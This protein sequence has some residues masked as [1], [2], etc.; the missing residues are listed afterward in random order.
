LL[1]LLRKNN[2]LSLY[3]VKYILVEGNKTLDRVVVRTERDAPNRRNLL[4]GNWQIEESAK[5]GRFGMVAK[6]DGAGSDQ[7]ITLKTPFMFM[8]S[9]AWQEFDPFV[10]W[11][12]VTEPPLLLSFDARGPEGGAAGFLRVEICSDKATGKTIEAEQIGL[13]WRHFELV[14][15]FPP[16]ISHPGTLTFRLLTL[17]ERPIEVKNISLR[18]IGYPVW[19]DH[20]V[21]SGA[22]HGNDVY[23]KLIELP[24]VNPGDPPVAIYEN[25]LW[26][27]ISDTPKSA[28]AEGC[29]PEVPTN[30][31]LESLKWP[32]AGTKL[33]NLAPLD[34]SIR[35]VDSPSKLLWCV[36]LPA[37]ILYGLVVVLLPRRG[38]IKRNRESTIR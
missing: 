32:A 13:K 28:T 1:F 8:P 9:Q 29:H 33:A 18:H 3:G 15:F 24:P 5:V 35:P 19:S 36:T 7:V 2:L 4:G 10:F 20:P 12:Y 38:S 14:P 21:R 34:I 17:S 26:R 27:P 22:G 11:G 23:K 25:R 16:E 31:Q 30:E 6:V 37:M